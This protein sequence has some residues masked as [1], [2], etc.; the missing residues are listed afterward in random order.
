VTTLLDLADAPPAAAPGDGPARRLRD[1]MAACRVRF[2]WFGTQKALTPEQRTRAAGAFDADGRL[3]SAGKRLVDTAHPAYRAVTSVRTSVTA[4]WRSLT[5]PFPE[6]GVRLIRQEN[7]DE[8]AARM[9]DYRAELADAVEGLDSHYAELKEA[10]AA[11]LGSLFDAADYPDTLRGL[12]ELAWD[13][14]SV[15]PPAYLLALCPRVYEQER[16][17]VAARFE[18]AVRLAEAAFTEEFAKL[19]EHLAE[20]V[21]GPGPDGEPKVFRD[22]AVGNLLDFFQRFRQLNVSS[23][24]QLDELVERARQAVRGVAAQDLR[25]S[26]ELRQRVGAQLARV[27][28]SLDAM[29]VDRP[30]RR[31]LR[32]AVA[33]PPGQA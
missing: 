2:T 14:P 7:V 4:Y 8:F 5:L 26:G 21:T 28:E 18:E 25:D 19:V 3:L 33:P 10:A 23:S 12:F 1:T 11:R 24:P 22:S 16:A 17:R 13:F 20:R 9:A 6:P 31:V 29:L 30:R 32:P 27:R 15:E